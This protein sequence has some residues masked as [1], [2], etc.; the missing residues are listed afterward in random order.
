MD[1]E[2]TYK[3]A[4]DYGIPIIRNES[5]LMLEKIAKEQ[6]PKHIL[7]IGT[8][9]GFSATIML[10][11]CDGDIMTIEHDSKLCRIAKQNLK[12]KNLTQRAKV[13][14]GDCLVELA[15]LLSTKNYDDYFD[16]IFLDG[17]KAQYDLMLDTLVTLL[18]PGGTLVVDNVLFRGYVE[19]STDV[20]KRYKTIVKRLEKFIENCKN[21][22]KLTDFKLISIEDGMIFAKKVK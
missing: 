8:A 19:H 13:I 9:I 18:K 5:H 12:E 22:K 4:K 6:N 1:T 10:S 3:L 2:S 16:L 21:H 11:A 20:P 15:K 7:E 14:E 17:P